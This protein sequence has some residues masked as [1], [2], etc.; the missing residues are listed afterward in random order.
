MAPPRFSAAAGG[1][2]AFPAGTLGYATKCDLVYEHLRAVIVSGQLPAGQRLYLDEIA[3]GLGLS[4]NPVR[5]A[6]RRLQSEGL[7]VNRPHQGA[8]VASIDPTQLEVHFQIRGVLEGLAARLAPAALKPAEIEQL[9]ALHRELERAAEDG[10]LPSWDGLNLEF[11]RRVFD[12]SRSPELI[13]L[14]NVQR[15]R[16]PRYRHFPGVLA[17]RAREAGSGRAE[18][19][20]ALR[21]GD[22]ER[23]ERLQRENVARVGRLLG[24]A[25]RSASAGELLGAS[26]ADSRG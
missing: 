13:A 25:I 26:S 19:L 4:T 10:D 16:S 23:A 3:R 22:G 18:L 20:D 24:A 7:V 1:A 8:I 2:P 17:R 11:Y 6:L 9:T 21:A 14:T 12:G 5:E 15:D